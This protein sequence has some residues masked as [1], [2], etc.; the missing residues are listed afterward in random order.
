MSLP[1]L[2]VVFLFIVVDALKQSKSAVCR[3]DI[4]IHSES[5]MFNNSCQT[6]WKSKSA[7][8]VFSSYSLQSFY[9]KCQRLG[10]ISMSA[11]WLRGNGGIFLPFAFIGHRS[12]RRR[13][14]QSQTFHVW[15][16]SS[17]RSFQCFI[18]YTCTPFTQAMLLP[19]LVV[20]GSYSAQN[21]EVFLMYFS[22]SRTEALT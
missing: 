7:K 15:Q 10:A 19:L 21:I 22:G 2:W 16:T 11:D 20:R 4:S 9:I 6:A 12:V 13:F 8:R 1:A 14:I 18:L 3:F 17:I 5:V